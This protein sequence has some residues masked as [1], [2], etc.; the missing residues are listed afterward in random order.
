VKNEREKQ[1]SWNEFC[2]RFKNPPNFSSLSLYLS[3]FGKALP[4]SLALS[5]FLV[6]FRLLVGRALWWRCGLKRR[7]R[8]CLLCYVGMWF[9]S[10]PVDNVYKDGFSE[11][12]GSFWFLPW[13]L[14]MLNPLNG[15]CVVNAE[16][17]QNFNFH[18]S[19]RPQK[20]ALDFPSLKIILLF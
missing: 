3:P 4:L 10:S 16:V 7:S 14:F 11:T 15:F 20:L 2:A 5:H 17:Q 8:L 13:L 9:E 6:G 1:K 18:S 19:L 12:S